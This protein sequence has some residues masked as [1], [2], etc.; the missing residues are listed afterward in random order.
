MRAVLDGVSTTSY[1]QILQKEDRIDPHLLK[2]YI[3]IYILSVKKK[4]LNE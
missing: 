4:V 1:P 3:N 2:Y